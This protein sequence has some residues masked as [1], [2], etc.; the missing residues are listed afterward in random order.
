[1]VFSLRF[2]SESRF[3]EGQTGYHVCFGRFPAISA[4]GWQLL[5][6]GGWSRAA[7]RLQM[8]QRQTVEGALARVVFQ[9]GASRVSYRW[10]PPWA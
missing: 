5:P 1:M 6:T 8:R 2:E 9:T 3:L 10:M 4:P 7:L